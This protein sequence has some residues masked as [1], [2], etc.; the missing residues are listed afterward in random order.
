VEIAMRAAGLNFIDVMKALGIYPGMDAN[1]L[2]ALGLECA[3][4]LTALGKNVTGFTVGQEVL[5]LAPHSFSTHVIANAHLI[6]PKPAG[7]TFDEAAALPVVYLTAYYSLCH[8]GRMRRGERVLIHSAAG[9]VGLAA[10]QL[11]QHMGAEIFATAGSEEKRVYLRSLGIRHVMDSR[12]LDYAEQVMAQTDGQGVDLVLNSLAGAAIPKSLA[13]LAPY[14]RFLEIGKRDIYQN[15]R[16]GLAPFQKNLSYFAIDLDRITRE[17]PE[18]LGELF[19]E[20]MALL[21]NGAIKPLPLTIF[22]V[23]QSAEAFRYMAQARHTGKIVISLADQNVQILPSRQETAQIK[24]DATYLITGG[25][26]GL[27]LAVAGWLAEQGARHLMLVGR[28][29]VGNLS[30]EGQLILAGLQ[31]AGVEVKIAAADISQAD[32]VAAF[33]RQI[34]ETMPPL[35]GVIHAAGVLD[36]G[37]LIQQTPQRIHTVMAPKAIGAWNLHRLTGGEALDFFVLFS[38]ITATFGSPGQGNYAAANAFLDGLAHHRRSLGLPALSIN[39]GPWSQIGLAAQR[40]QGGM[41][42]LQ[43]LSALS[44]AAGLEVFGRLLEINPPQALATGLDTASWCQA[45]PAA[46]RSTLFAALLAEAQ[47]ASDTETRPS[48]ERGVRASLLAAEPGRPRRTLLESFIQEQVGQVLRLPPARVD[49]HKP[50]RTLGMDSLMTIEFRNRLETSLG[51]TL[52]ATLVWNYPTVAELTPFL[53]E[54]AGIP[55]DAAEPAIPD[56]APTSDAAASEAVSS[57]LEQLS[58]EEVSVLLADELDAIDDLL[59]DS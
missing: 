59:K 32:Q 40:Q 4:L 33:L 17:R 48:T 22:P 2:P 36:D 35:R 50:L 51:L 45:H 39:W 24:P 11:A 20:V 6:M 3:G 5:A 14:G 10:V 42:G 7:L 58:D 43:G 12:S 53:A 44:P 54:K 1:T 31:A 9:G 41:Q 38:S 27:G 15:A 23:D 49:L 13:I 30:P 56:Q 46:G 18:F 19:G 21:N 34:T 37:V 57:E 8:L 47:T 55:L 16:L 25:L 26:G 28:S 52:S 29:G